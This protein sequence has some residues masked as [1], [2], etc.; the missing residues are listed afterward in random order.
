MI[1]HHQSIFTQDGFTLENVGLDMLDSIRTSID[2]LN[3]MEGLWLNI[4]SS[5]FENFARVL[6]DTSSTASDVEAQFKSLNGTIIRAVGSAAVNP[7]N[8]DVLSRS[9]EDLGYTNTQ[10]VLIEIMQAQADFQ[11][12]SDRLGMSLEDAANATYQ[13]TVQLLINSKAALADKQALW[14]LAVAQGTITDGTI[15]TE[16]NVAALLAEAQA[17]GLDAATLT[18]L[19]NVKNGNIKDT[20][21]AQAIMEQARQDIISSMSDFQLDFD[22]SGIGPL[23]PPSPTPAAPQAQATWT[24]LRKNWIASKNPVTRGRSPRKN[25]STTS[26]NSTSTFSGINRNMRRNMINTNRNTSRA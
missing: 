12:V 18:A 16:S 1:Q 10:E 17:A 7:E 22:L 8:F 23:P 21:A 24:P 15:A 2:R 19:E 14:Q 5:T 4:D 13:E 6:T 25:I 26:A 20:N 3:S 11:A 9:L